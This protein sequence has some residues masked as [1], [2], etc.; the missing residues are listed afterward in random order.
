MKR[1]C[2]DV[3]LFLCKAKEVDAH[4]THDVHAL[5]HIRKSIREKHKYDAPVAALV[6]QVDEL[7]P[8]RVVEPPYDD[9]KK[10]DN[11]QKAV[12]ALE[13]AFSGSE[14]ELLKCIPIS[15][16]AE[17]D[18]GKK[19]DDNYWN[20]DTLVDYL[21][22]VLPKEAQL[23]LARLSSVKRIQKKFARTM[24]GSAATACSAIAATPIPVADILPITS[25]Q[26]GMI[27]GIGYI[28]GKDMSKKTATEFLSALGVNVGVGFAL[29][30]GA[31]ALVKFVFPGAGN[32]ISAGVA[33]AG[34]WG[35][36]EA[37]IAYFIDQTSVEEA[38]SKFK[39]T[40]KENLPKGEK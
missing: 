24:V 7:A 12:A 23:Q 4:I 27:M 20:I 35:I 32:V 38:K 22:E 19:T 8:I 10:Q 3:I 36:G 33:F 40:K 6:T 30:Q 17:Y 2:T 39:K 15:A 31:R 28:A 5:C 21:L 9:A 37:A 11:I 34:T 18:D 29:R 26:I 25:L 13:G 1:T 14:I 16:Y